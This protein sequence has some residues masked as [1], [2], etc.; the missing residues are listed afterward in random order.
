MSLP[1]IDK[2]M[3]GCARWRHRN[4]G[5]SRDLCRRCKRTLAVTPRSARAVERGEVDPY[6]LGCVRFYAQQSSEPAEIMAAPWAESELQSRGVPTEQSEAAVRSATRFIRGG[7]SS[8][9]QRS[10]AHRRGR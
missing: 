3:L 10:S 8:R 4:V 5:D 7:T 6:C 9:P 1:G 2:P